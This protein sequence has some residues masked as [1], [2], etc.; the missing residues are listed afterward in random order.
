MLNRVLQAHRPL[1]PLMSR[2]RGFWPSQVTVIIKFL[3]RTTDKQNLTPSGVLHTLQ[4]KEAHTR[5]P[6]CTVIVNV[7]GCLCPTNSHSSLR[8]N[9]TVGLHWF[10]RF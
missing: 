3:Q 4:V 7:G 10:T 8:E 6:G 9:H 5:Q 1:C 2:G